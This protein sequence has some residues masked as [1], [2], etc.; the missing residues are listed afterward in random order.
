MGAVHIIVSNEGSKSN[1]FLD[2]LLIYKPFRGKGYG[3]ETLRMLHTKIREMGINHIHLRVFSHNHIA[4]ALYEKMDYVTTGFLM[5][6]Q[7]D[8]DHK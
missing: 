4:R 1:A 2:Y 7:L 3:K 6:K 8:D 5:L